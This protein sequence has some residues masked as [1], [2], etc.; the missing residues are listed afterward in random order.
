MPLADTEPSS[1]QSTASRQGRPEIR[2]ASVPSGHVYVR[3]LS[4]PDRDLDDPVRRLADPAPGGG[5]A[6]AG[7]PWWPPAMLDAAWVER[8]HDSFDLMHV[9]FGFDALAPAQLTALVEALRTHGKPLVLTVHDLRNPH[10]LDRALHDAQLDVLVPAASVVVTL[11]DGAAAEVRRRWDRDALVLPHPHVVEPTTMERL[12]RHRPAPAERGGEFR[13]GLHVKSLRACMDPATLLPTLLRAVQQVPGG[14]LQVDGHTDVL[15]PGGARFDA[16]LA[17]WLADA[18][19]VV[20]VRVHDYF[21]DDELV[22]YLA[23]LDLSV[24]PYRFGTHSGWLELCR[25]VGTPVAAPSCGY[26]ADQG[27]VHAF[28]FDEH[29]FDADSLVAAVRDAWT[30]T[31]TPAPTVAQ[32]LAQRRQLAEAHA[33][34][35]TDA[36]TG[37][38]SIA[39]VGGR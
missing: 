3:H 25:D 30:S 32:R 11:T 29:R 33:T 8:S 16:D 13:V 2:I 38:C 36:L 20:D 35:Y 31:P 4:S 23:S 37:A 24:L 26:Y 6:A 15:D 12:A 28:T 10:H 17:A 34:V 9:H 7:Q 27:P 22:D 21:T 39:T 5:P 14:V 19:V 18:P 1:G